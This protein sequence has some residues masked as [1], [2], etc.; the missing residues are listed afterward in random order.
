MVGRA[1]HF[2]SAST[3]SLCRAATAFSRSERRGVWAVAWLDSRL[4]ASSAVKLRMIFLSMNG[5]ARLAQ[6][7]EIVQ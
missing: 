7:L 6:H 5:I 4:A 3:V 1:I 2:R